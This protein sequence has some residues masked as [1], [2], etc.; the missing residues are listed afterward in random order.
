MIGEYEKYAD[1]FNTENIGELGMQFFTYI[2]H[3]SGEEPR[4][5]RINAIDLIRED[6]YSNVE[7][8]YADESNLNM[9][10]QIAYLDR[11]NDSIFERKSLLSITDLFFE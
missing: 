1:I 8:T 6:L 4:F 3:L 5:Y 9:I 2:G 11:L 10:N 7:L